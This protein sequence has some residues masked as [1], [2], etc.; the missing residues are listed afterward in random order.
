MR[1][2]QI[3][4][5]RGRGSRV[6]EPVET[7]VAGWSSPSRPTTSAGAVRTRAPRDPRSSQLVRSGPPSA[8]VPRL[9]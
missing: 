5:P 9:L 2:P 1:A 7:T 4:S 3:P 6:V 8:H